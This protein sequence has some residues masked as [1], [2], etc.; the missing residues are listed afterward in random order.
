MKTA[1]QIFEQIISIL[2]AAYPIIRDGDPY[3]AEISIYQKENIKLTLEDEI[4]TVIAGEDINNVYMLDGVTNAS[5][6][7]TAIEEVIIEY[8]E[9]KHE[10]YALLVY[11]YYSLLGILWGIKAHNSIKDVNPIPEHATYIIFDGHSRDNGEICIYEYLATNGGRIKLVRVTPDYSS[12]EFVPEEYIRDP[13]KIIKN[14]FAFLK[15]ID[16]I[17]SVSTK[18]KEEIW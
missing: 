14:F 12:Y 6:I 8:A 3:K 5:D 11:L 1:L 10:P 4:L 17:E 7:A 9:L 18:T 2:K 13:E 16:Y 15:D